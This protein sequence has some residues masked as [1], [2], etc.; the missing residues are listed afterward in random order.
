MRRSARDSCPHLFLA[1]FYC[2]AVYAGTIGGTVT[3]IHSAAPV[4][5]ASIRLHHSGQG[6]LVAE[7]ETDSSGRFDVKDLL[8]GEYTIE[9]TAPNHAR[10]LVRLD[11]SEGDDRSSLA[12]PLLQYGVITGNVHDE[13]GEPVSGANVVALRSEGDREIVRGSA[14]VDSH[15]RYRLHGLNPG[16]YRVVAAHGQ[17]AYSLGSTGGTTTNPRF[18]SGVLF[19]SGRGESM[20]LAPGG[21]LAGIDFVIRLGP[22]HAASGKV[23][24]E[25][26]EGRF[27]VSLVQAQEPG[28]AFAVAQTHTDGRFEVRGVSAGHYHLLA[29]GPVTGRGA[30]G[31]VL[32]GNPMFGR[33]H[34]QVPMTSLDGVVLTLEQPRSRTF[35]VKSIEVGACPADWTI[36]FQPAEDWAA[37]LERRV[38]AR[39]DKETIVTGL[40]P[41][42]YFVSLEAADS[43]CYS[44]S[45]QSLEMTSAAGINDPVVL[46]VHPAVT[47]HGRLAS[48]HSRTE[49]TSIVLL[50]PASE[51]LQVELADAFGH[52]KFRHLRPG[53]YRIMTYPPVNREQRIEIDQQTPA[54]IT[55]QRPDQTLDPDF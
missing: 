38:P 40:A 9:V 19:H 49:G 8:E 31:A 5:S 51:A 32:A 14:I 18:G 20:T 24:I 23:D 12:I 2:S 26:P 43:T 50:S 16:S 53:S 13:N 28:L 17:S 34:I 4:P 21:E 22:G 25:L 46:R 15:G 10:T 48:H 36:L 35:V 33:S 47:L 42:T 27:W 41:T 52:F 1:L 29:S 39:L 30:S 11:L 54:T 44:E 6:T 55:L 3:R 45:G 37:R 7:Q